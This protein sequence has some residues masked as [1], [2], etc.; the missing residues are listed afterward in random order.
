[1]NFDLIYNQMKQKKG[2]TV[3]SPSNLRR[4]NFGIIFFGHG[5]ITIKPL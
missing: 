2:D 4:E 3:A 5:R 1:M